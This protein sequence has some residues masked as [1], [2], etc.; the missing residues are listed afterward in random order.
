MFWT[1]SRAFELHGSDAD[2]EGGLREAADCEMSLEEERMSFGEEVDKVES[3]V[4]LPTVLKVIGFVILAITVW[5]GVHGFFPTAGIL[6]GG[7]MLLAGELFNK[8]YK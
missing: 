4:N 8:I 6:V 1:R 2:E 5:K 3:I 7:L